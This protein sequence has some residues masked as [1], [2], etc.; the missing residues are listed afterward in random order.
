MIE[1]ENLKFKTPVDFESQA[2]YSVEIIAKDEFGN[3]ATKSLTINVE[4]GKKNHFFLEARIFL[5]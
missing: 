2:I 5:F 3:S 4:D 1:D